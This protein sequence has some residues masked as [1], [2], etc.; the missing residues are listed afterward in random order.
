MK[1]DKKV[2][3]PEIKILEDAIVNRYVR[4]ISAV[5]L[6]GI[7]IWMIIAPVKPDHASVEK[8]SV[9][10]LKEIWSFEA[11]VVLIVIAIAATISII[12]KLRLLYNTNFLRT[13]SGYYFFEGKKRRKGLPSIRDDEDLLVFDKEHK[14]VVK[15]PNYYKTK[16][17][18]FKKVVPETKYNCEGPYWSGDSSG[19]TFF[20]KGKNYV[21]MEFE[22]RDNDLVVKLSNNEGRFYIKDYKLHKDNKVWPAE[23]Y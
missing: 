4:M 23:F 18:K 14:K 1:K 3:N 9:Y 6:F 5:A 19:F 2:V 7:G 20:Y 8:G 21:D 13:E 10:L 16:Y 12:L 22:I 15:F 11:G 17:N